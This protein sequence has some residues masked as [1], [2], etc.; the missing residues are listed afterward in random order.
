MSETDA[1]EADVEATDTETVETTENTDVE[2]EDTATEK[3]D[4]TFS[5]G[6]VEKLRD[7]NAKL[8]VRAQG[9]DELA[10]R[11]HNELVRATGKLA[12]AADLEFDA[13][14]LDD[15]DALTAAIDQLLEARPHLR[16]RKPTGDIG[17]GVRGTAEEPASLLGILKN[18]A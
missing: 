9:A 14:H 2:N 7:E 10:H 5:R 15:T 8:R 1:T 11:L 6:Y 3:Q 18:F 13:A 16:S 17:Q 4:E 12:D